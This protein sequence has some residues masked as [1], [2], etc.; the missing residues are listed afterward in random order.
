MTIGYSEKFPWGG[1]TNFEQK[2][3]SGEK[4][5]TIRRDEKNRWL[6]GRLIHHVIGNRTK[7][8]RQFA[9]GVCKSIQKVRICF[10]PDKRISSILFE[11]STGSFYKPENQKDI[12]KAIAIN[13]G[14]SFEDF[15]KWFFRSSDNGIFVGKII[16]F[17]DFKY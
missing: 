7:E 5:H 2:I 12:I 11:I 1:A 13:D 4:I 10:Y 15:E 9:E 17:T 16:H 6:P 14:L 3:L 8:R